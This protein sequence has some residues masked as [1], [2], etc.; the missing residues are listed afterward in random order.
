MIGEDPLLF[1]PNAVRREVLSPGHPKDGLPFGRTQGQEE[2]PTGPAVVTARG[3]SQLE[4]GLWATLVAASLGYAVVVVA[5]RFF[6][7][8]PGALVRL[9]S[10][11][12]RLFLALSV[13]YTLF[14]L[15][16]RAPVC[17]NCGA[18]RLIPPDSPRARQDRRPPS[19]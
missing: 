18:P 3:D 7:M 1:G 12:A 15:H 16:S 6:P 2:N 9:C 17:A 14:R 10:L 11:V 5:D 4:R 13:G 8:V 19:P